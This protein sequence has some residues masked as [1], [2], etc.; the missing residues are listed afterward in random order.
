MCAR[1]HSE[2]EGAW[3]AFDGDKGTR[4]AIGEA[5]L[6]VD[7]LLAECHRFADESFERTLPLLKPGTRKPVTDAPRAGEGGGGKARASNITLRFRFYTHAAASGASTQNMAERVMAQSADDNS[8]LRLGCIVAGPAFKDIAGS[9]DTVQVPR[10][11]AGVPSRGRAPSS[12]RNVRRIAMPT[13]LQR[14]IAMPTN[15]QRRIAM[16]TNL[17]RRIAMPTNLPR[18][19]L[20]DARAP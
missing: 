13:N 12:R 11:P 14:R 15:L 19:A 6:G 9:W 17:P 4:I 5:V 20:S 10:R 16:P 8:P 7:E 3:Q 18:A 1:R 2:S